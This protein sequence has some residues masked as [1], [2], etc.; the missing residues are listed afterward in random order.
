MSTSPGKQVGLK[1]TLC[2][3]GMR[4]PRTGPRPERRG[5]TSPP[6]LHPRAQH[7]AWHAA[8]AHSILVKNILGPWLQLQFT[9]RSISVPRYVGVENNVENPWL[10]VEAPKGG[11]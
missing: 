4:R 3:K 6:Y 1:T 5:C 11:G 8:G 2:E 10:S 9:P 7:S